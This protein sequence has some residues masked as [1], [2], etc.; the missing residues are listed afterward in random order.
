MRRY[1]GGSTWT[2]TRTHECRCGAETEIEV[3]VVSEP[4]TRNYPGW[5][6]VDPVL[7]TP[8]CVACGILLTDDAIKR[9]CEQVTEDDDRY[10]GP[11][12]LEEKYG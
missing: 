3:E 9:L 12:T 2:E 7:E 8:V 10:D 1:P 11:D 4:M 6:S 5:Y